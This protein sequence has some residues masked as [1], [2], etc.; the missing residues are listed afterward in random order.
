VLANGNI[1]RAE[2]VLANLRAT[3]A[4]G[5]M[6]AEARGS[7]LHHCCAPLRACIT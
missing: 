7:L 1:C 6:V 2:N 3:G 4:D 5:V